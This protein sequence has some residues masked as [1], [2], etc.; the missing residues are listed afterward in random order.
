MF[1]VDALDPHLHNVLKIMA[2]KAAQLDA[3]A[4]LCPSYP[5]TM[6]PLHPLPP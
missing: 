2:S 4:P 6:A 3:T 5:D 1:V